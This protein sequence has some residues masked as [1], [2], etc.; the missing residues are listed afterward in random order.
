MNS[1]LFVYAM[2]LFVPRSH[3]FPAWSRG[4][5]ERNADSSVHHETQDV[6]A[7]LVSDDGDYIFE[8][9]SNDAKVIL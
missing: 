1:V 9:I 3:W 2:W 8:K 6:T 5:Y 4:S 7:G